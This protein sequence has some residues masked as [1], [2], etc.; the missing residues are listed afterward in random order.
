A[1][2]GLYTVAEGVEDAQTLAQ[3]IELGCDRGQGYYWSPALAPQEFAA[4]VRRH[5][6]GEQAIDHYDI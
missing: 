2:L 1:S 3:L 6:A 4:F 5:R